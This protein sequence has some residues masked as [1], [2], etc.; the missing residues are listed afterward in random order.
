M[1]KICINCGCCVGYYGENYSCINCKQTKF[2]ECIIYDNPET[3][4]PCFCLG[5]Q[6]LNH[7][8]YNTI[9][10]AALDEIYCLISGQ[11]PFG[12]DYPELLNVLLIFADLLS[13]IGE[14]KASDYIHTTLGR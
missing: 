10:K 11:L 8:L 7:L 9:T 4:E 3:C 1:D 5:D 14:D 2:L 12:E 13:D 6:C